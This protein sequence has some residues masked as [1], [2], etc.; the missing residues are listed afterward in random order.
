MED[1]CQV[2]QTPAH[3]HNDGK[4]TPMHGAPKGHP[5]FLA[6]HATATCCCGCLEK[7]HGI[8]QGRELT[9]EEQAYIVDVLM[10]WLSRQFGGSK[11]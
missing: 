11:K 9:G 7:W 5:V 4:Q 3:P 2:R 6:Q 1:G 8:S 10:K